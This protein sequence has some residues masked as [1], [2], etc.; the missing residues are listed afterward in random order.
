MD[1]YLAARKDAATTLLDSADQK[2]QYSL[3]TLSRAMEYVRAAAPV[4]GVQRA[5]YD[6]FAM[7]FQTLLQAPSAAALEKL[8]V[9]HLLRGQPL[10]VRTGD[11]AFVALCLFCVF[12]RSTA[13][14]RGAPFMGSSRS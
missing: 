8:M 4:Y 14:A 9:K 7:S 13:P 3:R 10:K 1:F 6:G 5:L 12:A 2:P 11:P